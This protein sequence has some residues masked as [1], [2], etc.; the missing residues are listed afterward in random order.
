MFNV[1]SVLEPYEGYW[2][3]NPNK[4][5]HAFITNADGSLRITQRIRHNKVYEYDE[6][7]KRDV[8]KKEEYILFDI[9]TG[10]VKTIMDSMNDYRYLV[11]PVFL[12]NISLNIGLAEILDSCPTLKQELSVE[13]AEIIDYRSILK[14]MKLLTDKAVA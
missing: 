13:G 2:K 9:S 12:R 5:R 10:E 11:N 6:K 7:L 3:E 8:L 4:N 14:G 1:V